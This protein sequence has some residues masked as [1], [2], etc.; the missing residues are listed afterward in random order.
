M[1]SIVAYCTFGN[2]TRAHSRFVDYARDSVVDYS[3]CI[4]PT[5]DYGAT[6][7]QACGKPCHTMTC[8]KCAQGCISI[9]AYLDRPILGPVVLRRGVARSRVDHAPVLHVPLRTTSGLI[10]ALE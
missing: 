2:T 5:A 7:A 8:L 10:E 9:S 1:R 4:S 3:T 6:D